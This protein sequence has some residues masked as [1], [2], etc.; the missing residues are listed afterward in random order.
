MGRTKQDIAEARSAAALGG[1]VQ[2]AKKRER[3][4]KV[5]EVLK[6]MKKS[7]DKVDAIHAASKVAGMAKSPQ[8]DVWPDEYENATIKKM[9]QDTAFFVWLPKATGCPVDKKQ[10]QVIKKKDGAAGIKIFQRAHVCTLMAPWGPMTKSL[11]FDH[12]NARLEKVG[13]FFELVLD[14]EYNIDWVQSGHFQL[15]PT[16][17]ELAEGDEDDFI[18]THLRFRGELWPISSDTKF[19]REYTVGMNWD[20]YQAYIWDPLKPWNKTP[21]R[22]IIAASVA[23]DILPLEDAP[24]LP[25]L[26][27]PASGSGQTQLSLPAPATPM[28]SASA[29]SAK[30]HEQVTPK[31]DTAT[32]RSVESGSS[33]AGAMTTMLEEFGEVGHEPESSKSE[34][35]DEVQSPSGGKVQVVP[36]IKHAKVITN[37]G[38]P[39]MSDDEEDSVPPSAPSLRR[40]SAQAALKTFKARRVKMPRT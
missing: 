10:T 8:K 3:K 4:A 12:W 13:G 34:S 5:A 32:V 37:P 25:A 22:E 30:K 27:A 36:S 17:N 2:D 15:H 24:K 16:P 28:A 40:D 31:T 20:H 35:V 7:P 33:E 14:R 19:T 9:K 21:C 18:Y 39:Q 26:P 38:I 23:Q 6:D 1:L 11:W 29:D